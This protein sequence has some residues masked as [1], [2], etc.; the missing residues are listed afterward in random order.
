MAYILFCFINSYKCLFF[1][2][3]LRFKDKIGSSIFHQ[4]ERDDSSSWGV[5]FSAMTAINTYFVNYVFLERYTYLFYC[6][7]PLI[8]TSN[9]MGN[10]RDT[11]LI[12]VFDTE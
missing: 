9:N 10:V 2:N 12:G 5:T 3:I 8:Y 1:E 4:I 11:N 6:K 7:E